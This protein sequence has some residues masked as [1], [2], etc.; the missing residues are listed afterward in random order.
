MSKKTGETIFLPQGA[1]Q[2]VYRYHAPFFQARPGHFWT[3]PFQIWTFLDKS[4][5]ILH[6]PL[7]SFPLSTDTSSDLFLRVSEY[8]QSENLIG[9]FRFDGLLSKQAL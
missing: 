5:Y 7:F 6:F 8:E 9:L 1:R 3:A 2:Q 4:H